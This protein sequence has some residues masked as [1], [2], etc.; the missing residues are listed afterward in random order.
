MKCPQMKINVK[1]KH[2]NIRSDKDGQTQIRTENKHMYIRIYS[3]S[4]KVRYGD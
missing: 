2:K 1:F 3:C 4:M